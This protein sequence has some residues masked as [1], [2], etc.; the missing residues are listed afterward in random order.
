MTEIY[1]IIEYRLQSWA[2]LVPSDVKDFC[3]AEAVVA[4]N[5]FGHFN[6]DMKEPF[7]RRVTVVTEPTIGNYHWENNNPIWDGQSDADNA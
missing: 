6:K 2:L 7:I 5:K 3:H 4:V 1:Y